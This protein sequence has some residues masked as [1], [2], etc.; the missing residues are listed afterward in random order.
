MLV[1]VGGLGRGGGRGHRIGLQRCIG[2][3]ELVYEFVFGLCYT[4]FLYLCLQTAAIIYICAVSGIRAVI[5][6]ASIKRCTSQ[7]PKHTIRIAYGGRLD[8]TDIQVL[9]IIRLSN[10]ISLYIWEKIPAQHCSPSLLPAVRR[11]WLGAGIQQARHLH[12]YAFR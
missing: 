3:R 11:Y 8:R 7:T 1:C 4:E 6:R 9:P 5:D 2:V 10:K 12:S